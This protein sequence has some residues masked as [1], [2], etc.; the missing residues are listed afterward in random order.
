MKYLFISI[1][2]LMILVSC[3]SNRDDRFCECLS[4]S[5]EL[6]TVAE[7]IGGK[8][9]DKLTDSDA[10]NLKEMTSKK[11]SICA[12]YE[13]LSGEELKKKQGACHSN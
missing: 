1:L 9:L 8:A 2:G 11:D 13:N 4:V 10:M 5:K 3:N 12:P 7:A 6:N